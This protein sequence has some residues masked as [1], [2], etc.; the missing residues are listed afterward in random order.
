MSIGYGIMHGSNAGLD[1]GGSSARRVERRSGE[2]DLRVRTRCGRVRLAGVEKT[3]GRGARAASNAQHALG[4]DS[5]LRKA[6]C[7]VA[8][9]ETGSER[10]PPRQSAAR[11]GSHRS[12]R[13]AQ[14]ALLP[15][16]RRTLETDR[17]HAHALCRRDPASRAGS[18]R[19]YH[20]PRL[21]REVQKASR[22][23]SARRL[24]EPGAGQ[25]CVGA[26][27]VAAL[28]RWATRC[29]KSSKFSIFTCN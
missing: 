11:A 20:S 10:R 19:A 14:V 13:N 28:S 25:S 21:V 22:A 8:E 1:A 2:S 26:F 27:G 23:K 7:E 18:D 17:R 3:T 29:R 15:R 24:A 4:H 16:L 9:E 5:R 6:A 12:A